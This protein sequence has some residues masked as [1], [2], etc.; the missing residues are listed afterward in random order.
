MLSSPQYKFL[1]NPYQKDLILSIDGGGMRGVI[2]LAILCWLEEQSGKPAYE[3]FKMVGGTST[4]ALICAGLGLGMSAREIMDEVYKKRLP[5]AF[6]RAKRFLWLRFLLNGMRHLYPYGPFL[7]ALGPLGEGKRV[8]DIE[9]P[10]I[11][12]TTKDLRTS[13]TYYIINQGPGA[14]LF[15]HWPLAGAVAAS[16]AAPLFFPPVDGNLVD[17]G[18]G[19]F[20]NPCLATSVEAVEYLDMP[21]ENLVHISLG[22]GYRS[23]VQAEGA[24][25][26]FWL[27]TWIEY[28]IA[29]G[30]DDA[31]LQ[32]VFMTRAIYRSMDF[33]RYNPALDRE[34]VEH[35]LDLDCGKIDPAALAL[36]SSSREEIELM[37]R[38]GY[39]YAAKIDW[40]KQRALPWNTIG[41]HA[42]PG[43]ERSDWTNSP[44]AAQKF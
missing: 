14:P 13:S 2:A 9:T 34:S 23:N 27:K 20:G 6:S 41:G 15:A 18:V 1:F 32:Q 8:G 7:K 11:L 31:A 26:G 24:G 42:E 37:E 33:R 12:L 29:E 17:G 21:P 35:N 4:G 43:Y 22:N 36:D 3:L 5:K 19:S 39:A 44:F 10:V 16:V 28:L 30:L 38:I 40:M 25:R